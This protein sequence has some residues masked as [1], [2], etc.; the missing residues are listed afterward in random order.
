EKVPGFA[1]T[2]TMPDGGMLIEAKEAGY[3]S[4]VSGLIRT[5]Y[6]SD[7][8][9]ALQGNIILAVVNPDSEKSK[10]YKQDWEEFQSFRNECKKNAKKILNL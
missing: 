1:Y 7:D 8:A 9:E 10:G 3:G 6:S 2:G 5:R 4:F